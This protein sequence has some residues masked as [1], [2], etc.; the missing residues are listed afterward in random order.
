MYSTQKNTQKNAAVQKVIYDFNHVCLGYKRRQPKIYQ[1]QQ[2]FIAI[3]GNHRTSRKIIA[4]R[5]ARKIGG[6]FLQNPPNC[7]IGHRANFPYGSVL[8]RAYFGLSVYAAACVASRML[9][10]TPVVLNGYWLDQ[11]AF[12][13]SRAYTGLDIPPKDSPMYKWPPDLLKPDLTFYV[14]CPEGIHNISTRV[15]DIWKKSYRQVYS[16]MKD[17]SLFEISTSQG[18]ASALE[19]IDNIIVEKLSD[20]FDMTLTERPPRNPRNR[21]PYI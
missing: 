12:T 15:P 5:L 8:R 20:Q 11:T 19:M 9:T 18:F 2:P 16:N 4:R 14:D 13:I 21:M 1:K 17:D 10:R 7:L 6:S 3:E